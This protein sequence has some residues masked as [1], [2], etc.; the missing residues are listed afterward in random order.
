MHFTLHLCSSEEHVGRISKRTLDSCVGWGGVGT[1]RKKT[2]SGCLDP[3]FIHYGCGWAFSLNMLM[4]AV[5]GRNAKTAV[6]CFFLDFFFVD[7]KE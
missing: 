3:L 4:F 1:S 2:P 7:N 5:G 6:K